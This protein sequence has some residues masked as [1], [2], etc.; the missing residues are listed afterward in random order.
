MGAGQDPDLAPDRPD[1]VGAAAVGADALGEDGVPD[2][3][4]QLGFEGPPDL[5][6]G[7]R[8]ALREGGRDVL[9][10]GV[11]LGLAGR[12]VGVAGR[13]GDAPRDRLV[14][15]VGDLGG[16]R[17][18]GVVHHRLGPEGGPDLKLELDQPLDLVM[19]QSQRLEHGRLR[20]LAGA[21]LHHGDG[22]GG[23]GDHQVQVGLLELL[24]G[25]VQDQLTV[26]HPDPHA[27][28]R[29]GMRDVAD[30]QGERGPGH[31]QGGGVLLLVGRDHGGDQLDVVAEVLG[32]ERPHR[33]VDHPAG[34]D[35]RL[36]G[37]AL[38]AGEAARDPSRGIQLLLVV[39]GEGEEVDALAG[40][41]A[42]D[43]GD[44]HHGVAAADEEGAV[45][46][47]GDVSGLDGQGLAGVSRW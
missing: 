18:A 22:V 28:D 21:R 14:H 16:D 32:E 42:G 2:R 10:E 37:T 39:A 3:L 34:E 23:A 27:A 15:R 9:A 45:R 47:L 13:L 41:P 29:P 26:E 44:Q 40:C 46:L 33:A 24:Q 25:R 1:L 31:R 17:P 19:G 30:L 36:A 6:A 11:D 38:T 12:L 35:G 7:R 5:R 43:R 20:D 8:E 4:L